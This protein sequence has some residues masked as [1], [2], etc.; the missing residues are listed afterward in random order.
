MKNGNEFIYTVSKAI[1]LL[2]IPESKK[3]EAYNS[4]INLIKYLGAD[5]DIVS[6]THEYIGL[7]KRIKCMETEMVFNGAKEAIA[8]LRSNGKSTSDKSMIARAA[9]GVIKKAYG[10]T[11]KYV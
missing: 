4:I 2:E 11:W 5:C 8:W 7:R 1:Q 9:R 6:N 3:S 10:L